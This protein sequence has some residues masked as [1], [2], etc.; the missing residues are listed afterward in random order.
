MPTSVRCTT[1]GIPFG[2]STCFFVFVMYELGC[3]VA[4]AIKESA[5]ESVNSRNSLVFIYICT[6]LIWSLFPVAWLTTYFNPTDIFTNESLIMFANFGAKVLFSSSI[7]YGNYITIAQR[8]VM[9]R[10]DLENKDRIQ[11]VTDLKEA[12]SRKL[13][14]KGQHFLR[15]IK[16]SS[17][18]LLNIINDI[19]DVAAL[20]EGKLTIKHEAVNLSKAVE[21]VC[22]IVSPLAKKEVAI[23][24]RSHPGTPLIVGDFSRIVQILYNLMGNSLKFTQRGLVRVTVAPADRSATHVIITVEDT[25]I[26]ISQD[27]IPHIWGA[28]EQVGVETG[29]L[30]TRKKNVCDHP[31]G[32]NLRYR[33]VAA[34]P[35]GSTLPEKLASSVVDGSRSNTGELLASGK[36]STTNL[37]AVAASQG[38]AFTGTSDCEEESERIIKRRTKELENEALMNDLA[39]RTDHKRSMDSEECVG[40]VMAQQQL[41]Q[42]LRQRQA[43]QESPVNSHVLGEKLAYQHQLMQ[44]QEALGI[45]SGRKH[46]LGWQGPHSLE[47][48]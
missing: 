47:Q 3:M 17:N 20:K 23:E 8:R 31:R 30:A 41:R 25:G 46:G 32:T 34:D 16:N 2:L 18:H 44:N 13:N 35:G 26:G 24:R 40:H 48:V 7:M 22:D 43:Q 38:Q 19:L 28:F 6:L 11:M 21:H 10:L 15:T 4:S 29:R 45:G 33:R 39:R 42:R 36:S 27:K 14:P 37:A 12:V 9:A 5:S 1:A